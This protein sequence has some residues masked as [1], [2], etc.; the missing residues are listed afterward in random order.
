MPASRLHPVWRMVLCAV[1]LLTVVSF[2]QGIGLGVLMAFS[3]RLGVAN[4]P[5]EKRILDLATTYALHLTVISYPFALGVV[6]LFRTK[7]DKYSWRSL[8]FTRDRALPNFA[9]G[10]LTAFLTLLVLFTLMWIAGT[11]RF[12]GWST[13]V[14]THSAAYAFTQLLGFALAFV[15]VGFFEE[16]V[17]R[18]YGMTNLRQWLGWP[19]AVIIQGVVFAA[20]HLM[21]G[22][23][24]PEVMKAAIAGL[25]NLFLIAVFFAVSYRKTGS[26]WFP[27][28]F[29]VA[30]NWLLGCVFSLPVSGIPIFHLFDVQ[31]TGISVLSG[32]RFG[33]EGS[34]FL[35]PLVLAMIYAMWLMPDHPR[36]VANLDNPEPA[37]TP[38]PAYIPVAI[39]VQVAVAANGEEEEDA[40]G[41]RP[42]RYNARFGSAEGFDSDMLRE[43]KQ[44]NE[45]REQAERERLDAERSARRAEEMRQAEIR[46]AQ[47]AAQ[48]HVTESAPVAVATEETV[49][50]PVTVAA[51]ATVAPQTPLQQPAAREVAPVTIPPAPVAPAAPAV[52]PKPKET[53]APVAP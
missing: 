40:D 18:G 24:N 8:G 6:Y 1:V 25:P 35:I 53:V 12:G 19:A 22:A 38:L 36:A 47:V 28:G 43:L 17:F 23:T 30:W 44:M 20:V 21:N 49:V 45:A 11:I 10:A 46:R 4:L 51:E 41:P 52:Q 48:A 3:S 42:N 32:G 2:I 37:Q 39:P 14:Q 29:H 31:E 34:F 26:L 9:R 33:A 15:A 50:A 27:I 7:V 16:T 5:L 13:Q